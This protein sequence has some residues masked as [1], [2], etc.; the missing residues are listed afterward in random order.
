MMYL[1]VKK[2]EEVSVCYVM[3]YIICVAIHLFLKCKIRREVKL[4]C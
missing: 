2:A 4:G 3:D 1:G